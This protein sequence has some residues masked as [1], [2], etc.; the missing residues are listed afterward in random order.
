MRQSI[1][2][3][4]KQTFQYVNVLNYHKI[5]TNIIITTLILFMTIVTDV[6]VVKGAIP[7]HMGTG[8]E[9]MHAVNQMERARQREQ[10]RRTMIIV[11]IIV[12]AGAGLGNHLIK[13]KKS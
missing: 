3:T 2:S 13:I 9:V 5:L 6:H 7:P 4:V 1:K 10:N 11:G 8:T 12:L